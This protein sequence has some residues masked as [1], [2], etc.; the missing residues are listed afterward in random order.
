MSR[1]D[2]DLERKA[3]LDSSH[4]HM[5]GNDGPAD[6]DDVLYGLELL[7]RAVCNVGE[8]IEAAA[9]ERRRQERKR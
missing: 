6:L 8:T 1:E 2:R 5:I 3:I 9:G 4:E 7:T